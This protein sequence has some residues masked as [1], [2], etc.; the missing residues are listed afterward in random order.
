MARSRKFDRPVVLDTAVQQFWRYGYEVSSVRGLAQRTGITGAGPNNTYGDKQSPG[1]RSD[2]KEACVEFG[3]RDEQ[4]AAWMR[5]A[6][7]GDAFAYR[8]FLESVTP[9][10]RGTVAKR[11]SQLGIPRAEVEDIVQNVLLA[12]HIKRGTWDPSR[13][14]GPWL[15]AFARNKVID[16]FRNRRRGIN[17]PIDDVLETLASTDVVADSE[18]HGIERMLANL[19]HVQ[20]SIVMSIS[21]H[22]ESVTQTASR[23]GMS[24]GAVRVAL[25]RAIKSLAAQYRDN[26]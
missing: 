1:R 10:L 2:R 11:C 20:R 14:I 6:I 24:E 13:P 18:A 4:W 5:A 16:A 7:D 26:V 8:R 21:V 9:F 25:H 22:G 3:S 12:I 15:A 23:L 17:I 19:K